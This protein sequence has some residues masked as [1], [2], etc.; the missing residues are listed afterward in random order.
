MPLASSRRRAAKPP[1]R[2]SPAQRPGIA[3]PSIDFLQVIPLQE[4]VKHL[5]ILTAGL[6]GYAGVFFILNFVEPNS[7]QNVW[8]PN[9]YTPLILAAALGHFC[10]FSFLFLSTRRGF[11][12]SLFL[13][14]LLFL[15]LQDVLTW[16]I[17]WWVGVLI[18][19]LEVLFFLGEKLL[20]RLQPQMSRFHMP[21]M[22]QCRRKG[23]DRTELPS[24]LVD[25]VQ[26]KPIEKARK[27]TTRRHGRKRKYHFFGK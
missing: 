10:V 15:R 3:L 21:N 9:T 18:L 20:T 19:C 5:P 22:P 26:L 7:I 27:P 23:K 2:L 8:I 6:A 11:L 12:V 25:S 1:Q 24:D 16:T 4:Y 14:I 17:T 13:S